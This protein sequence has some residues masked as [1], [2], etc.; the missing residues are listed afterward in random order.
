MLMRFWSEISRMFLCMF[1]GLII[2]RLKK[3]VYSIIF[4]SRTPK[5][6]SLFQSVSW[7][8]VKDFNKSL[9]KFNYVKIFQIS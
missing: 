3:N 5:D 6:F 2:L 7:E 9:I 1:L 4:S 8:N